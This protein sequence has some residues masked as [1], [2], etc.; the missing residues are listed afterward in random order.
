MQP[1]KL[2]IILGLGI[3]LLIVLAVIGFFWQVK[4]AASGTVISNKISE[5]G[6]QLIDQTKGQGKG[7]WSEVN[8]TEAENAGSIPA[9]TKVETACFSFNLPIFN[10]IPRK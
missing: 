2:K 9:G 8:L 3:L 7:V 4:K 6:R 1:K 5:S 10:F